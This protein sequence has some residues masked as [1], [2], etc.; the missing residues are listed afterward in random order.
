MSDAKLALIRKTEV[1]GIAVHVTRTG[2]SIGDVAWLA[3]LTDGRI[4][5]FAKIN[6]RILGIIPRRKPGFLGHL[7][8]AAE[9]IIA[10]SIAHGDQL[11]V[12][13]IDLVPE[14]LANGN[15][16]EIH[17]SIW[18]NPRHLQ[19]VVRLASTASNPQGTARRLPSIGIAG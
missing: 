16:P 1:A 15:P 3:P 8:P 18:G 6:R 2:L 4:G 10:P 5:V 9:S 19:P 12:R 17:I 13:I 7:G 14:H 11:R